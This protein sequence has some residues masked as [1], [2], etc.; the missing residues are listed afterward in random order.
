MKFDNTKVYNFE[1]AFHG[2]RNPMNSWNLSDSFFGVRNL[3]N[4]DSEMDIIIEDWTEADGYERDT[5]DFNN[6]LYI[7]ENW[8]TDNGFLS[9]NPIQQLAEIAY[10]GPKDMKLAKKLIAAGPEHRKF[11]RQIF[12]TVDITAPLYW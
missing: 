6:H 9:L 5:E 7:R 8:L 11:M 10:I 1:G 3:A 12:V 2:M 4:G